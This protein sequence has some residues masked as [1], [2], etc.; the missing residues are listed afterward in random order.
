MDN[1]GQNNT[2]GSNFGSNQGRS[3]GG[4]G[5]TGGSDGLDGANDVIFC[6][7]GTHSM[8]LRFEQGSEA[9]MFCDYNIHMSANYKAKMIPMWTDDISCKTTLECKRDVS[10]ITYSTGKGETKKPL[11]P[12]EFSKILCKSTTGPGASSNPAF[13]ITI[14]VRR[15]KDTCFDTHQDYKDAVNDKSRKIMSDGYFH[16]TPSQSFPCG[17]WAGREQEGL[18]FLKFADC[19]CNILGSDTLTSAEKNKYIDKL[20]SR[21]NTCLLVSRNPDRGFGDVVLDGVGHDP[22]ENNYKD[23]LDLITCPYT[24]GKDV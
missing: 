19:I 24:P 21:A 12:E 14:T 2:G 22:S 15:I 20:F 7:T 10:E 4:G 13:G 6:H 3:G 18:V 17:P 16:K 1:F 11:T 9:P 5:I 8:S 23:C